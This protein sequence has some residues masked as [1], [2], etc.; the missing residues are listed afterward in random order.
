MVVTQ[1]EPDEKSGRIKVYIDGEYS[2]FLYEKEIAQY[3]L[4]EEQIMDEKLYEEILDN[5]IYPRAKE[6][7]LS[8]LGYSDRSESELRNKL[9]ETGYTGD[10]INRVIDYVRLYDYINDE[11]Y[12]SAFI[13]S[14]KQTKSRL[15]IITQLSQKGINKEIIDKVMYNEY[16]EDESSDDELNAIKKAVSRK[17]SSIENLDYAQKQRLMASLYRKGFDLRK[18]KKVLE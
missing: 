10:V 18:I 1:I 14:K 4:E 12:T 5:I 6:K 13:R 11:R 16:H 3:K 17:T 9:G 8:V 2:F 7:A 15:A